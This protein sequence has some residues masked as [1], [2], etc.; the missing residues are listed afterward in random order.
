MET[1]SWNTCL[2]QINIS[3]FFISTTLVVFYSSFLYGWKKI[4]T[5][6]NIIYFDRTDSFYKR[7]NFFSLKK[8]RK[9]RWINWESLNR[10]NPISIPANF[11]AEANLR[12]LPT[13][14]DR[15]YFSAFFIIFYCGVHTL[16]KFLS[17][18]F[19][20][21]IPI[22]IRMNKTESQIII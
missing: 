2:G 22:D 18:C 3:Y 9:C 6:Q 14:P 17:Y 1:M 21:I 11:Q 8:Q 16:P 20:Y 5:P 7:I 10:G 12:L 13:I 19:I 15:P 4:K